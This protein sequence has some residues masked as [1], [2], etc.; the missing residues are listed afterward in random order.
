MEAPFV[1]TSCKTGNAQLKTTP[2]FRKGSFDDR[3]SVHLQRTGVQL[4]IDAFLGKQ[5][6]VIA[7]LDD[8]ALIETMM[9][10]EF[11]IVDR[12][13]AMTN[14][15]RPLISLS[16]PSCTIFSVRE[17][18]ELVASSRIS[19]GALASAARAMESS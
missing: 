12:R 5:A 6:L 17:S 11:L 19:T 13:W 9:T 2:S 15:V 1:Q 7:T 8:P 18:I 3:G 4:V 16:M 10:S 14:V